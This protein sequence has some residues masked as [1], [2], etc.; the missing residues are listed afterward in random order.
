MEEEI[1]YN[2]QRTII[3]MLQ[4]NCVCLAALPLPAGRLLSVCEFL[5]LRF[6]L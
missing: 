6:A 2:N 5:V 1:Y 3:L 4:G